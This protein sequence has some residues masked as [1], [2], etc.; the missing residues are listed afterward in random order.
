MQWSAPHSQGPA[1]LSVQ[2]VPT[3]LAHEV[4]QLHLNVPL[5]LLQ[6]LL[7]HPGRNHRNDEL[8]PLHAPGLDLS[9]IVL[10]PQLCIADQLGMG[11]SREIFIIFVRP[12]SPQTHHRPWV[13]ISAQ[14]PTS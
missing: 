13:L 9:H 2:P 8:L 4:S 1:G 5:L 11:G 7:F 6:L 10:M 14:R 3:W 12:P